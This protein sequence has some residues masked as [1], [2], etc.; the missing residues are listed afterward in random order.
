[1]CIDLEARL[2]E[3]DGEDDHVHL[4]VNYPLKV[5]VSALVNSVKGVA[6]RMIRLEKHSSVRR[7]L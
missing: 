2:V 4:L 7:R 3:L 1:V 5:S 6:S